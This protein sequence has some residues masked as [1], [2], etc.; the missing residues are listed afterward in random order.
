MHEIVKHA[1]DKL[2]SDFGAMHQDFNSIQKGMKTVG[3]EFESELCDKAMVSILS[4]MAE[5]LGISAAY[6]LQSYMARMELLVEADEEVE[7]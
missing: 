5:I 3:P 2:S 4:S 6:F 1:M 7:Q